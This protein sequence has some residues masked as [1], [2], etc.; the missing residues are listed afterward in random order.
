M[1]YK[2]YYTYNNEKKATEFDVVKK[3]ES[4]IYGEG[5]DEGGSYTIEGKISKS[6]R[7]DLDKYYMGSDKILLF[8]R[9]VVKN[10]EIDRIYGCWEIKDVCSGDFE[11]NLYK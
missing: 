11:Y 7:I 9:G 1:K 10:G 5:K 8:G 3:S 6:G 2:G 4:S